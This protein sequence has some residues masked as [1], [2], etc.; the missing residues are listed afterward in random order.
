MICRNRIADPRQHIGYWICHYSITP[1]FLPT[2][3]NNSRDL[4]LES[5]L[6]KRDARDA[7][8]SKVPTC[9]TSLRTAVAH[10][11]GRGVTRHLLQL[12]HRRINFLR[13]RPRIV[14]D[15]LGVGAT[16]SKEI[17]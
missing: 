14:D 17:D 2:R 13:R 4:A 5:K 7:K 15:P 9:A 8:L 11:R 10:P 3:F 16:S 6:A 1:S 12:D